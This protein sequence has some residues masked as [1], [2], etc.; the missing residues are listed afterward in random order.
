MNPQYDKNRNRIPL[1]NEC[2]KGGNS[3]GNEFCS[4][5]TKGMQP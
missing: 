1:S 5:S 3:N 4:H 2:S